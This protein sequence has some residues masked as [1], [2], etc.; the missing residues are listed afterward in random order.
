MSNA[1]IESLELILRWQSEVGLHCD[2]LFIDDMQQ[3]ALFPPEIATALDQ[4]APGEL[5]GCQFAPGKLVA[6]FNQHNITSFDR[7]LM[8]Q[9]LG[10]RQI[11]LQRGRFYPQALAARALACQ[12]N[13]YT[14]M[15]LVEINDSSLVVDRNHPLSTYE[16]ELGV[17]R[18]RQPNR[19]NAGDRRQ[20]DVAA[21]VTRGGPGMQ[22]PYRGSLTDFCN[23]YP[24]RRDNDQDDADFYRQARL[25]QHLDDVAIEQVT[26]LHA[27]MI[28]PGMK[29]LDLMSSHLSHLPAVEPLEVVGLGMNRQEL[30]HNPRLNQR[31]IHDL[32]KRPQLPFADNSFDLAICTS[33]IEYLVDPLAV[34]DELARVLRPGSRL[35]VTFSDRWFSGKEITLWPELH[36]FERQGL[37]LDFF[38]RGGQFTDLHSESIRGLPR[39]VDDIH[40]KLR[41]VSDPVFAVWGTVSRG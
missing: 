17:R 3:Q 20:L 40:S 2:R 16:L 12:P 29:V 28:Q 27:R 33:S 15:R 22:M 19:V 23:P 18:W 10:A 38:I 5:I 24:F 31:L 32:N 9:Q 11:Q 1:Q 34:I 30:D 37:V 35:M 4:S 39:P 14:P 36:P 13:D 7:R 21:V 26:A 25:V 6:A 8:Q 41:P